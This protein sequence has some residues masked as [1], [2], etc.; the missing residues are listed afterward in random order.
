MLCVTSIRVDSWPN[1]NTLNQLEI[2]REFN[3]TECDL[4][5]GL[6]LIQ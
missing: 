2:V 1:I 5:S 6:N 3:T 4:K